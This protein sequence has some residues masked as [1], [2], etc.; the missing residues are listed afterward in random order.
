MSRGGTLL[1]SILLA[2][3]S[4]VAAQTSSQTAPDSHPQAANE[5]SSTI[6][7]GGISSIPDNPPEAIRKHQSFE[8]GPFVNG[9]FGLGNRDN[10]YFLSAGVEGGKILTPV[11]HAGIFSGQFQYAANIMPL[12]QA[13]TPAPH[14]QTFIYP[15][16][17]GT[18]YFTGPDGGG[19]YRGVSITPVILRWNFLTKS[20]HFQPW[21][22]GAGGLIY[23]THKFP[24]DQL[25]PHGTPGG[26]SVFNFT[27]QGGGGIHWFTSDRGSWDLGVNGVHISSASLGDRNPG[28]N[29][30]IQIQLGYTFW[31]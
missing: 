5:V 16:P 3:A 2:A 1:L 13:Y 7:G 12:W 24:P 23:T 15:C 31:K 27:P 14:E 18:C 29:A 26:T 20:R 28:V 19:T 8:Y 25:V 17:T 21:F 9:G 30:S 6:N 22:Q 4:A 11:F 10:F